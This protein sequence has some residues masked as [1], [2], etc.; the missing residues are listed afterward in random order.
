MKTAVAE[1][2]EA[3]TLSRKPRMWLYYR[4]WE[5]MTRRPVTPLPPMRPI[6][7]H[8]P[9]ILETIALW[10]LWVSSRANDGRICGSHCALSKGHCRRPDAYLCLRNWGTCIQSPEIRQRLRSNM[11]WSSTSDYLG[12]S[13]KLL[14]NRSDLAL[15]YADHDMKRF[16]EALDLAQK[17]LEVRSMTFTPGTRW[18]GRCTKMA[19]AGYEAAKASE[20]AIAVQ[21]HETRFLFFH[22]GMIAER[23]GQREQ[24]RREL[25]EALQIN[26][27]FHLV[28]ANAAQQRLAAL[29]AQSESKEGSE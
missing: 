10:P 14:H 26:P 21:E 24:A 18:P 16:V 25:K 8:L 17:E 20:M 6:L 7:P 2:V 29:G 27:H 4:S 1:G 9:S 3:P 15:F 23:L 11:R 28:Y 22:A 5:S 19:E 13:I 12:T